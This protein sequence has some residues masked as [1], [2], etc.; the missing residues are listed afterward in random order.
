VST[1]AESGEPDVPSQ[2]VLVHGGWHG[3][4]IWERLA[5][6]LAALGHRVHTPTLTGLGERFT[7]FTPDVGLRT[8][9][10]D[11]LRT[12]HALEPGPLTLVGHSYGGSIITAVADAAPDR[13]TALVY[14]DA[15]IPSDGV[16][17]W[18]FFAP[19]R[20]AQMLA[21]AESL[22]G[23]QVPPPDPS[24][25]GFEPDSPDHA[26]LKQRLTPHP[27][28][29]MMDLPRITG[30]WKQ[31]GTKC[32]LLASGPPPS[33]FAHLHA[34]VAAEPGWMT[35]VVPGGH[36]MMWTHPEDLLRALSACIACH[37][38]APRPS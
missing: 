34:A 30:R 11:I 27:L 2:V 5:P 14:L 9:V 8:H 28:K 15:L 21:G 12:V 35:A 26:Y 3:G 31:V 10:D 13:V 33:R 18:H 4:W 38:R 24:I 32:Y 20:Q 7:A 16:P 17:D 36:E 22:G 25:W 37:Q 1:P 19:E 29:T 23:L 6:R